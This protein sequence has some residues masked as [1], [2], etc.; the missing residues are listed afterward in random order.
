MTTEAVPMIIARG[1]TLSGSLISPPVNVTLFQADWEK[2]GPI[3]A[4]PNKNRSAV[5]PSS[6]RSGTKA[7]GSQP[8]A[9][10]SHHD[11]VQAALSKLLPS[12][13]PIAIRPIN[14]AV[15]VK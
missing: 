11:D 4:S 6:G 15:L 3:I 2:S 1:K 10:E 12:N 9:A 14:A 5:G 7:R 13:R 8:L